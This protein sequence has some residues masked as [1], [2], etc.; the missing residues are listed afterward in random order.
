MNK[1]VGVAMLGMGV[2]GSGVAEALFQKSDSLT[3]Q[4]GANVDLKLILV[5]DKSKSRSFDVSPSLFTDNFDEIIERDDV[6]IVVEVMGGEHPALEF[7]LAALKAGKHVVTANKEV[8]AKHGPEI[9]DIARKR[10]VRVLFEASVAGG[11]PVVSPLMRDLVANEVNGIKAII[12]GTTNYM[13]TRMSTE[14]IDYETVLK[15]AQELGYAEP[16]PTND[17]E[18]IDAAYKLA[19]LST[20]GFRAQVKDDDVFC[21]GITGLSAKDFQYADELGYTIK[22]LAVS[23][24]TNGEVQAR[25]HPALVEKDQML[26]KVDGV[27]NAIE[28]ETDLTGRVLFHGPGAGSMPTSSAIVA[29][30][31]NI[32]RNIAGNAAFLDPVRLSETIKVQSISDL[33]TKYYLRLEAKDEPGVLAQIGSALA[34]NNISISSFIQKGFDPKHGTAELVIMTHRATERSVQIAVKDIMD[35]GVV[36]GIGNMIR[37]AE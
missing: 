12:N 23:S 3:N 7:I 35:L 16:D 22:L 29:D 11:T 34:E 27:L 36:A 2:V 17:V 19:I 14:N 20:L 24:R 10:D 33:Q 1:S 13:L 8:M 31:I 30:I 37:V 4:I 21:E 32:G 6:D 5:R 26:A 28:I 25:V 15:E 9:F 18:G